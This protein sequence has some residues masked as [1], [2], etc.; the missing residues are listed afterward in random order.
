MNFLTTRDFET[1]FPKH[2]RFCKKKFTMCQILFWT[3]FFKKSDFKKDCAFKKIMLWLNLPSKTD[4]F[5]M[6][7]AFIKTKIL[8]QNLFSKI[9]FSNKK[10]TKCKFL[11]Q[12]F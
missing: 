4:E 6:F 11:K 3:I 9:R 12:K 7:C 1:I 10:L 2:V 5:S 8:T